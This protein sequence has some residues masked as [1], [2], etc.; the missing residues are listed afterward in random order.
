MQCNTLQR[1][2]A[3]LA[4][5]G[6][7]VLGPGGPEEAGAVAKQLG[8]L[9]KITEVR[10]GNGRTYLSSADRIPP[11]TDHPLARLILWYCHQDDSNGAGANILVDTRS[12]IR[13]LPARLAAELAGVNLPCPDVHTLMPTRTYPLYDPERI[14][15]FYAPWLCIDPRSEAMLS[16][17]AEIAKTEHRHSVLL[18]EGEA[19]LIDNRRMLHWRDAL[20]EDSQR[21][22]TRYWI[23]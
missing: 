17:E 2:V 8:P 18:R 23:G 7:V 14:Q 9:L 6:F 20:P 10:I 15:V 16:F 4:E 22:L 3:R 13:A 12:V 5:V 19:L 11:H 1:I 21:W